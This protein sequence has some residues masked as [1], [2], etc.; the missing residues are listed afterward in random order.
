MMKYNRLGRTNLSVSQLGYGG[1]A[2]FFQP[3]EE[4]IQI[5]NS[6]IDAGINYID[7]DEASNQFVADAMYADTKNKL[8]EVLKTR[9]NEIYVG[10]KS[11]FAKKDEIAR[12]IDRA[13]EYIFKGTSREVV[14][15]FHLAHID[16]DEK[17]DLLLSSNG[18]LIAAEEAKKE[19]KIGHILIASH[20]PQVLLRAL[21][22][23]RFDVAEFP[24]TIIENEYLDEVIPFCKANDIGTIIMKPIGGGRLEK[25]ADLSLRWILQH[26]IDVVI[27]GMK[28]MNELK[29]NIQSVEQQQPLSESE[30]KELEQIGKTIGKEYCHRCGYCLPCPQGIHIISQFDVFGSTLFDI[31]GKREIFKEIKA[32][33]ANTAADCVACETCVEKCPF[34][35]P[36]PAIMQKIAETI[37]D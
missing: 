15:I 7:C 29:Q 4:A 5:I 3:Q 6:A 32:R 26:D 10:I 20:N 18:G 27:P 36:V 17:L 16:V 37:C 1:L 25:C 21:K 12:D 14:D 23:Q 9:R 24:F 13:L 34:K 8:G 11:M 28:S 22:T 19:G 30:L 31:E 33:G 35:L 2:L